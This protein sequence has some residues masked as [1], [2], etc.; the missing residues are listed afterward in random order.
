MDFEMDY[1]SFWQDD[2][3]KRERRERDSREIWY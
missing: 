3:A 2:P 1:D